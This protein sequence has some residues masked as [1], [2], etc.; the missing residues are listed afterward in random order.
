MVDVLGRTVVLVVLEGAAVKWWMFWAEQ[1][2]WLFWREQL[3]NGGC[4]GQ[5]SG[6]GCFGGSS[7]EMVDVLGRT[8]VLV[9]LD[10]AAVKWW[11]F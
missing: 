5:N 2:Y 1:W 6:T 8:V 11:M 10:G 3:S 4:F 9:V 7:C